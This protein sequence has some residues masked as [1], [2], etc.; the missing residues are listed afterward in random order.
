M[1]AESVLRDLDDLE[2]RLNII[3][4]M[5]SREDIAIKQEEQ[6]QEALEGLM[7]FFS[8]REHKIKDISS[9]RN[10]LSN[11]AVYRLKAL[12]KLFLERCFPFFFLAF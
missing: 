5:V 3:H 1:E 4:D 8:R 12:G 9:D 6:M 2:N 11:I 10:L 7:Y